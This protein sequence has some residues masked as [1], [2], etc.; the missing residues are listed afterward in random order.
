MTVI[1]IASTDLGSASHTSR[2]IEPL[3]RWLKPDISPA[4]L[5]LAHFLTR[6]AAHLTAYAI[7]AALIWRATAGQNMLA[8]AMFSIFLSAAYAIFDEFHQSFIAT[9]TASPTDVLIDCAGAFLAV[10]FCWLRLAGRVDS[11]R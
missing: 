7:L 3:L 11:N 1:F 10:L 2:F 5:E 6:K 9:R 4:T 8:R